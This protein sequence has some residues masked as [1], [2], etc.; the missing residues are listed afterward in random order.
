MPEGTKPLF[1]ITEEWLEY[2]GVRVTKDELQALV[3]LVQ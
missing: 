3:E 2:D 1:V